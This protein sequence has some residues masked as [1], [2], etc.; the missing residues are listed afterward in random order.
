MLIKCPR[1]STAA[2]LADNQEGA[3]VRCASC[4]RVFVARRMG[5]RGQRAKSGVPP[6]AVITGALVLVALV[7]FVVLNK[8]ESS[9]TQ[10]K[11][12]PAAPSVAKVEEKPRVDP[13]SFE[14]EVAQFCVE[15][16]A[17][18]LASDRGAL[19]YRLAGDEL[20]A[21]EKEGYS[22]ED[23]PFSRLTKANQKTNLDR[24]V[25]DLTT[26]PSSAYIKNW[27]P[28][29][30]EVTQLNDKTAHIEL[31][32]SSRDADD[33]SQQL[34]L[35]DL[36]KHDGEWKIAGWE[37]YKAEKGIRTDSYAV[38]SNG[39]EKVE[40]SD[41]SI[42]VE[43]EAEALPH[44]ADTPP[45]LRERIDKLYAT[46]TDLDLTRESNKAREELIAI[47]KPAIPT[48]L[49]GLFETKL[50]TQDE[51]IK[52][53]II[54]VALRRITGRNMGYQPMALA[55]EKNSE[56]HRM[57]A[58]RQWFAWWYRYGPLW[59]QKRA[60]KDALEEYIELSERE[61]R[62]LEREA[63]KNH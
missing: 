23:Q 6:A 15:V 18:A 28:Y 47:G 54:A 11:E 41:G 17:L 59:S 8:E 55:G 4:D 7:L 19:R 62:D 37:R 32:V 16:H 52:A 34:V 24:W 33:T 60:T 21:K 12:I 40:L 50:D 61:K 26:G 5:E 2:K 42:V 9:S 10:A 25:E 22:V 3:K 46:M 44:L 58:V 43:R 14:G 29:D 38:S 51:S 13:Y 1:C 39:V 35:W 56:E 27:K 36:V 20:L 63:E 31:S 53:N 49:T 48:L 57:S 45:E 30:S